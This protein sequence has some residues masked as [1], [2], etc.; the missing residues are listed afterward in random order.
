[1]AWLS[2]IELDKTVILWSDWLVY[3][4]Y[5]FS[6]SALWCSLATPTALLG[7]LL[8]WTWDISSWLLQQSTAAAL[9]VDEGYLLMAT[10]SDLEHGVAPLSSPVPMQPPL[11]G[12]GVAPLSSVCAF[13]KD[14]ITTMYSA[15][16]QFLLP[17]NLLTNPVIFK[18]MLGADV[19]RS[20]YR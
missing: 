8:P 16:R 19:V 20:F 14:Y 7:F 15:W 12:H 5:G 10:L 18:Y 17:E 6:V 9:T 2:F 13:S 4:D 1:M 3:C 11:L